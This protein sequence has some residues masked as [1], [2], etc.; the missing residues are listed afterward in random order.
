[1]DKSASRVCFFWGCCAAAD[2]A[3]ERLGSCG[4]PGEREITL[5]PDGKFIKGVDFLLSR[6]PDGTVSTS[7]REESHDRNKL[8]Q[9]FLRQMTNTNQT[10]INPQRQPTIKGYH[11]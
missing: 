3:H 7:P 9:N 10:Q 2:G 6:N 8:P 5:L 11:H 1:M 4:Y